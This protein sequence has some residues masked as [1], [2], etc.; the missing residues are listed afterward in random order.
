MVNINLLNWRDKYRTVQNNKFYFIVGIVV[1]VCIFIVLVVN[2]YLSNLID[3]GQKDM[4]FLVAE[5]SSVEEK[6]KKIKDLQEQKDLL[7]ARRQVIES[8]QDSRNITVKIFDSLPRIIPKGIVLDGLSRKGDEF[9]LSGVGDSNS[10]ISELMK[11]IQRL[12]LVR[13]ATLTEIK[14]TEK[15]SGDASKNDSQP[16][17][18]DSKV[19]FK[20]KVL[21][22]SPKEAEAE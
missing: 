6:I 4:A 20:L 5:I 22:D 10:E 16:E 9:E 18:I 21:F 11:N 2:M 13:S 8:L 3:G 15:T 17:P 7:L 19:E 14:S 1:T 12:K